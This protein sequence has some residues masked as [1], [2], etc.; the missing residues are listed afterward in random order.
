MESLITIQLTRSVCSLQV[1]FWFLRIPTIRCHTNHRMSTRQDGSEHKLQPVIKIVDY[2]GHEL[3]GWVT[4]IFVRFPTTALSSVE[5]WTREIPSLSADTFRRE[6]VRIPDRYPNRV[7][8]LKSRLGPKF[9][10]ALLLSVNFPIRRRGTG[11]LPFLWVVIRHS[12]R[13]LPM[14]SS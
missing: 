5:L 4:I 12:P 8:I 13:Y 1:P 6:T 3:L 11:W 7:E 2:H 10:Y 14:G 9:D